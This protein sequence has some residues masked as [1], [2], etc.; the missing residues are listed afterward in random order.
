MD[1]R[2]LSDDPIAEL[3]SWLE[4]AQSVVPLSEAMTLATVG[5]DG[6]PSARVVLLRRLDERGLT[7]FT[8]RT[9]RKGEELAAIPA[10]AVVFHW[11]EL[12][13]QVRVEGPVEEISDEESDAYWQSRPRASRVAAWAS[14]QSAPLADRADLEARVAETERRFEGTDV[15]LP[16]F[17]G[18][19]RVIPESVE[20]WEHHD[21]RLHDR[22]LYVR[23]A[24]GWR[25]KRLAP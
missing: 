13:R 10:A 20:L 22:I 5:R 4:D 16:G 19:Y 21:D 3:Q 8:N 12:G 15:P 24:G 6:R 18:G 1:E 14:P 17:W 7:F 23:A 11:R 2:A 25:R 9:S